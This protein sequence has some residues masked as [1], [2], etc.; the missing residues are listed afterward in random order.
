M[1]LEGILG[2]LAGGDEECIRP[3]QDMVQWWA[4]MNVG[5]NLHIL[6]PQCYL[7]SCTAVIHEGQI[8]L[9]RLPLKQLI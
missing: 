3:A 1:G 6:V 5:M 8:K 7:V 2:R 4:V 9:H